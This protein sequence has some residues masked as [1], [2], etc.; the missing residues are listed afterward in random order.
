MGPGLDFLRYPPKLLN[1]LFSLFSAIFSLS[2]I[3]AELRLLQALIL[4]EFH[5]IHQIP[6]I[7]VKF[8]LF[9]AESPQNQGSQVRCFSD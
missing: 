9:R 5:K 2:Y 1:L 7:S 8:S 6:L 3:S 4:P